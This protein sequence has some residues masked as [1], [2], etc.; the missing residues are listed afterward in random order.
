MGFCWR[1]GTFRKIRWHILAAAASCK[2]YVD[3]GSAC[4]AEQNWSNETFK[5]SPENWWRGKHFGSEDFG[6]F[7]ENLVIEH[8]KAEFIFRWKFVKM[9]WHLLI[10]N[11]ICWDQSLA[12]VQFYPKY[13]YK[14]NVLYFSLSQIPILVAR[15][16]HMYIKIFGGCLFQCKHKREWGWP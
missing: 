7:I 4:C 15:V 10:I 9:K 11:I 12:N 3:S 8:F 5:L 14:S 13:E 2:D 16:C 6:V 1:G